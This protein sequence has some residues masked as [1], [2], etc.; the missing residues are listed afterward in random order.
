[1]E[2]LS[3]R[4]PGDARDELQ[5]M[6]ADRGLNISVDIDRKLNGRDPMVVPD[7]ADIE[8]YEYHVRLSTFVDD[9]YAGQ[10]SSGPVTNPDEFCYDRILQDQCTRLLDAIQESVLSEHT[11]RT[12]SG[13]NYVLV[14][15]DVVAYANDLL[16]SYG[17]NADIEYGIDTYTH[18]LSAKTYTPDSD[19]P[20]MMSLEL[21]RT[22]S[23]DRGAEYQ[24]QGAI[25]RLVEQFA[26][27]LC[28]E[29]THAEYDDEDDE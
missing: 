13:D 5:N 20:H 3:L 6:A 26:T 17:I 7:D 24:M 23:S 8:S 16:T 11:S 21:E 12:P 1:M 25:D 10:I 14:D 19:E 4:N 29:L 9:R 2:T 15:N 27:H 22:C 28:D 18:E